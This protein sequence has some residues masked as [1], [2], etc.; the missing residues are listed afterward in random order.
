ML[1]QVVNFTLLVASIGSGGGGQ[2]A[3]ARLLYGMGRDK[4][5]PPVVLRLSRSEAP[6]SQPERDSHRRHLP[7]RRLDD[8]LRGWAR[9]C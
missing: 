8:H 1:F 2:L 5:L 3:G 9:N 4:A 6:G 7:D